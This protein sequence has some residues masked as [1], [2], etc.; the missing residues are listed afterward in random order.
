MATRVTG[1]SARAAFDV[2]AEWV[3]EKSPT[4]EVEALAYLPGP[5]GTFAPNAVLTL[6]DYEGGISEF[7]VEALEGLRRD[8]DQ[9]TIIAIDRWV[10]TSREGTGVAGEGRTISYTHRSPRT[11]MRLRGAEWLLAGD[12]LAVQLTTT[13]GV[14]QWPVFGAVFEEIAATLRLLDGDQ[15][16]GSNP[17]PETAVDTVASEIAGEPLERIHGL[18]ELQPYPHE[19]GQW[20]RGDAVKLVADMAEG[21]EV[22]SLMEAGLAPQLAELRELGLMEGTTLTDDG[23][24]LAAFFESP[25]A[26][27]RLTRARGDDLGVMQ[28][29]VMGGAALVSTH[30]DPDAGAP[31]RDHANIVVAPVGD[32]TT[33]V[34]RWVGL[35]PAWSFPLEAEEFEPDW[36]TWDILASGPESQVGPVGYLNAGQRGH[37]LLVPAEESFTYQEKRSDRVFDML[38][39]ILQATIYGRPA[40]LA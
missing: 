3:A 20:I 39:E 8:L 22:G 5:E 30:G 14:G 17:I 26:T 24:V 7:L 34:A 9:V 18:T 23:D 12:G 33:L 35:Q 38:E 1:L 19:G 36:T 25:I 27:L 16:P 32:V 6:N 15:L 2:P 13:A 31:S 11:G 4:P 29:W 21:L 40:R 10:P 28:I 37:Y